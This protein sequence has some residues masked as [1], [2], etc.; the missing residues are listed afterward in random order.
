MSDPVQTPAKPYD[1]SAL[2]ASLKKKGLDVT[3]EAASAAVGAV[4]DW[5]E[6]S[7]KDSATPFDD[8]ALVVIPKLRDAALKE[9]DKIDGEVG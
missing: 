9:I 7:A 4:C 1:L 8:I 3:E 5:L 2:A 6:Q